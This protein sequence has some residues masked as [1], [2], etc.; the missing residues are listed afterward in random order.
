MPKN[1]VTL[2]KIKTSCRHNAW[3]QHI[4]LS[5]VC[6]TRHHQHPQ[7]RP[8]TPTGGESSRRG[9]GTGG[10][11]A[12]QAPSETR[13]RRDGTAGA[14]TGPGATTGSLVENLDAEGFLILV[15]VVVDVDEDL[16]LSRRL[17][18]REAQ[19]DGVHLPA[20]HLQQHQGPGTGPSTRT[21]VWGAWRRGDVPGRN[22]P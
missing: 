16:L 14:G 22:P 20:G 18:G 12:H 19:P 7:Q 5:V 3:L 15:L 11:R 10:G 6:A 13:T 1:K 8:G 2:R 17:A 21:G 9:E 4:G